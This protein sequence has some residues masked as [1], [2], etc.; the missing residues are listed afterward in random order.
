MSHIPFSLRVTIIGAGLGG[1]AA[2]IAIS[3]CGHQ[4]EILERTPELSELGA[5]VQIHPNA[6][7]ILDSW[8]LKEVVYEKATKNRG[9]TIHRYSDGRIIGRH[10]GEALELYQYQYEYILAHNDLMNYTLILVKP[11]VDPSSGLSAHPL[12]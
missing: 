8:G 4:V 5:G 9:S 7:R 6:M 10:R 3:Q 11:L 2:A 12:R 1:L